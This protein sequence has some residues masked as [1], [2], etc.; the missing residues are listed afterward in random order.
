MAIILVRKLTMAMRMKMLWESQ[1]GG[2]EYMNKGSEI[3]QRNTNRKGT[4]MR[5]KIPMQ[6]WKVILVLKVWVKWLRVIE[7][8][9]EK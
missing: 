5:K 2:V 7:T 8:M 4:T 9:G 3:S 1:L 6:S